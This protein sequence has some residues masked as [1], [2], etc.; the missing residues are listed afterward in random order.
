M[1]DSGVVTLHEPLSEKAQEVEGLVL[2]GSEKY[3]STRPP[4]RPLEKMNCVSLNVFFLNDAAATEISALSLH[5]ALPI[6]PG[7]PRAGAWWAPGQVIVSVRLPSE[8]E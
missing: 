2:P 8:E 7:V 4:A 5:D 3:R 6:S 1:P